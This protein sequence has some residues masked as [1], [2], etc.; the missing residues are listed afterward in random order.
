MSSAVSSHSF[1]SG[2]RAWATCHTYD[3]RSPILALYMGSLNVSFCP[4]NS[5][6]VTDAGL[7]FARG[8]ASSAAAY[9]A[10]CESFHAKQA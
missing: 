8:L 3:N 10:A 9:L 1:K 6:E 5:N 2:E 7:S 4:S